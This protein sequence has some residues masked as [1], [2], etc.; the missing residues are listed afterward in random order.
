MI[1]QEEK[2]KNDEESQFSKNYIT[3]PRDFIGLPGIP[4]KESVEIQTSKKIK[5][6]ET[7]NTRSPQF[8]IFLFI[9][10]LFILDRCFILTNNYLTNQNISKNIFQTGLTF[11]APN[12]ET[13]AFDQITARLPSS[14][15]KFS[16]NDLED[17]QYLLKKYKDSKIPKVMIY[18]GWRRGAK[19]IA[20]IFNSHQDVFYLHHSVRKWL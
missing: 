15:K 8:I 4:L 18:S 10:A 13:F 12:N 11:I 1:D 19:V 20:N 2:D 9:T 17:Y 16:Q 3:D 14:N 5:D 6:K 7:K